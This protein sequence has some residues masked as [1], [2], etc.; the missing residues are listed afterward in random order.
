M[1]INISAIGLFG[2]C[3]HIAFHIRCVCFLRTSASFPEFIASPRRAAELLLVSIE[4]NKWDK[5][6]ALNLP[7]ETR[8]P[9]ITRFAT[10]FLLLRRMKFNANYLKKFFVDE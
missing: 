9:S 8:T 2:C 6:L 10:D 5:W 1:P 3:F 7:Y 4:A